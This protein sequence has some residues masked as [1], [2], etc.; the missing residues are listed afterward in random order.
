MAG[1][2]AETLAAAAIAQLEANGVT[3]VIGTVVNPAGLIHAKT[4]PVRRLGAFANPGLGASP[5]WHV[6]AIDKAGIVFGADTGVVGDQRIRVDLP[7]IRTI[8]DGFAW[9]PG[10]FF[11]QDGSPD[12][13]CARGTLL[14]VQARLGAAG[15]DALVGHE[16]EFVLVGPD[17]SQLPSH[18][19]AQYGLA[20]VLEFEGFVRDV[21][22][23]AASSNVGIEQFH[24]EYGLNQFE[25]S[26]TP[27][28][29][30]AA[31]DQLVLLRII[32]ARVARRY[33]LRVSL[34]PVPFAGSVGSGAHQHFSLTRAGDPLFSGGDG[35]HGMTADGQ[36]AVAGL[37]AGL[38]DAQ[39][40]LCGSI[41]SG[42]RMLPGHWSGANVCWGTENREAAVRFL[43]GGPA[44]PR[45]ANVEVKVVDP[46][47]NPYFA[48][49]TILGLALNGIE[50]ALPLP[51]ETPGDPADLTDSQRAEA[52]IVLLRTSQ[53]DA[54]AALDGSG[55]VRGILGDPA[56]DAVVAVRRYEAENFGEMA[57]EELA[58]KFR[59]AWSV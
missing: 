34:S 7:A 50:R 29:P 46:S 40:V 1:M 10:A 6:F 47:A 25:I 22:N 57:P 56:V 59:L 52:G 11:N 58:E 41:L 38:P 39:A 48:S 12:A 28:S 8:G 37:L 35:A 43:V 45:G 44:N 24:P 26:L 36:S 2:A 4:V 51:P 17:G 15:L 16:M 3:T 30:V 31:A 19:W 14:T 55:L 13:Y 27:L 54:V 21:V 42:Q 20:G 18:L 5:C 32:V 49:A 33:G 9:G 53:A 23:A